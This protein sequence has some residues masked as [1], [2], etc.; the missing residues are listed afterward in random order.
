[1]ESTRRPSPAATR[2]RVRGAVAGLIVLTLLLLAACTPSAPEPPPPPPPDGFVAVDAWQ[3]R[4][5]GYLRH[6]TE[7]LD[8][9]NPESILAALGRADRDPG[10]RIDAAEFTPA[11]LQQ[12]FDRIDRHVDTSDF[13]LM[14]LW[15]LWRSH[16]DA[17]APATRQALEQRLLGFR[18]WYTDPLPPAANPRGDDRSEVDHK[19][20][21]SENHRLIVHTLE[22]LAGGALPDETFAISGESGR[23]HADRG[24]ARLTA[25]LDEKARWGFSEWHSD[26][27]YPEDVQA[28]LLLSEHA[29]EPLAARARALLDV[30]F[31]DFAMAQVEGNFGTTH[32]RSYMKD[33]SRAAD[34]NTRDIIHFLYDTNPDGYAPWVDFGALLLATASKYRLP[35]V[36]QHIAL[37]PATSVTKQRMGVALDPTEPVTANPM[38]PPGTSFTDPEALAFWWD[39]GAMTAWQVVPL[40]MQAIREHELWRGDLFAP[41]APLLRQPGTSTAEGAQHVSYALGCQINAGLLSEAHTVTWRSHGVS[42]SSVQDYR[43]G[44]LGRQYHAWQATLGADAVV[45][46]THPGNADRGRWADDDLYWNGSATMPRTGQ[47]GAVAINI[48]APRFPAAGNTDPDANYQPFTHAFFPQQHFDEVRSVGAWTVARKGEGYV[49]LWSHRPTRWA[50]SRPNPAGLTAPYDL[51]AEGGA[52]NVWIAEVGTEDHWGDFDS[53][54]TAVTD[55]E[56]GAIDLGT[57]AGIPRGYVVRYHSPTE[58]VLTYATDGPLTQD[59]D[60]VDQ[61]FAE[62]IAS[63]W[64]T[65]STDEAWTIR[66]GDAAFVVE[67][68]TGRRAAG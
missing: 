52:G 26:V 5:R 63:P 22:Y 65:A 33:K 61:R 45:F 68:S 12:K 55:S 57:I 47:V 66:H 30:L 14:R 62:R 19:W 4:Q 36:F 24:R 15:L 9:R 39:R 16:G 40:S 1:M 46:T 48:Y 67:L 8:R 56:V 13:D 38:P 44:C 37:E 59:A 49:A 60:E 53:F 29:E 27:Y 21:W 34:Q 50:V 28:L 3:E 2:P 10:F 35:A 25:W 51:V 43:A 11:D 58:G 41:V 54:V 23:T 18:Y 64:V 6:A 20:F 32:G 17:L 31:L 7:T 42:L